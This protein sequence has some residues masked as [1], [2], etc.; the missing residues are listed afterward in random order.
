M[1]SRFALWRSGFPWRAEEGFRTYEVRRAEAS[2][3]LR[4]GLAN[5]QDCFRMA[6][7]HYRSDS[8]VSN[9]PGTAVPLQVVLNSA[10]SFHQ[11]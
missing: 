2:E 7:L 5:K 1:P 11:E 10:K 4:N 9:S 8:W 6:A 3:F